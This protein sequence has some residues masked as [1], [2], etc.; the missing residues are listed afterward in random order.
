MAQMVWWII[1]QIKTTEHTKAVLTNALEMERESMIRFL[2]SCY[3]ATYTNITELIKSGSGENKFLN[4]SYGPALSGCVKDTAFSEDALMD[5]LYIKFE[6]GSHIHTI[7]FNRD[8]PRQILTGNLHLTYDAPEGKELTDPEWLT[9]RQIAIKPESFE[10][11]DADHD[12]HL[13]MFTMEGSFFVLLI[14]IGAYMIYAALRRARQIDREQTLFIHSI[15]HELKIPITSINLFIDTLK[16][17]Q[18]S[19]EIAARIIPKMKEDL[20]RLNGLIDNI[21]RVRRLW[22]KKQSESFQTINL[23]DQLKRFAERIASRINSAGA[24]LKTDIE[25]NIR[26]RGSLD[27]LVRI[28]ESLIDNSIKYAGAPDLKIEITLEKQNNGAVL[29]FADNGS[30]VPPGQEEKLLYQFYRGD[31]EEV[32]ATSGSGLGLFIARE[33]IKRMGGEI[34]IGNRNT[35]GCVVTIRLKRMP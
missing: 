33:Y 1:F 9:W 24:V 14:L 30:G 4:S 35:G 23:S 34:K 18:Y 19:P 21:L 32:R 29:K 7:F 5:S 10:R 17:H 22:D 27:D 31:T 13:R 3:R 15:T 8:Y 28:W 2:N 11:I 16:R 12:R 6:H 25:D 26:V 20:M